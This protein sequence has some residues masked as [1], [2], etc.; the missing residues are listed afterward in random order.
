M[1]C[2][3]Q[4]GGVESQLP[5]PSESLLNVA[6]LRVSENE[7]NAVNSFMDFRVAILSNHFGAWPL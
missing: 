1:C 4:A 7:K 3:S 6:Y 2:L 5:R